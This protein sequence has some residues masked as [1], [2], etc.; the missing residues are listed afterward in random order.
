M[1]SPTELYRY[2]FSAPFPWWLSWMD[3][4]TCATF[5][6]PWLRG[7]LDSSLAAQQNKTAHHVSGMFS[8]DGE[9]VFSRQRKFFSQS[10][11]ERRRS[12]VLCHCAR[13][14]LNLLHNPA[15][16][17]EAVVC[18]CGGLCF[19]CTWSHARSGLEPEVP[20]ATCC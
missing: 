8:T 2:H 7:L 1:A 13:T 6:A 12:K 11:C 10:H 14:R 4:I 19:L 20:E 9:L 5:P 16:A 18:L 17:V 15:T 3:P